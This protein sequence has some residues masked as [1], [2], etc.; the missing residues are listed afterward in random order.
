MFL[1]IALAFLLEDSYSSYSFAAAIYQALHRTI[2]A[3][4]VGWIIIACENGYG[5]FIN[6]MLSW[7]IWSLLSKISYSSYLVHPI[8]IIIYIG[9]QE[10]SFHFSGINMLYLFLGHSVMTFI[11]GLALTVLVERPF[12]KMFQL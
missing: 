10:T 8:T 7:D 3:A 9:V 5:G 4:A 2:W 1:V 12:Q 6:E 11:A